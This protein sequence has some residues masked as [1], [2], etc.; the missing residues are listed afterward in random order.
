MQANQAAVH[1]AA[2]MISHQF[3]VRSDPTGAWQT[4]LDRVFG[5]YALQLCLWHIFLRLL[6]RASVCKAIHGTGSTSLHD[7]KAEHALG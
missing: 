6:V 3:A 1:A 2:H 4:Y 5:L 7:W